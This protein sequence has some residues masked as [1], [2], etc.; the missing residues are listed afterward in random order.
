MKSYRISIILEIWEVEGVLE[1]LRTVRLNGL[2]SN[3]RENPP[4]PALGILVE[5]DW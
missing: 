5:R 2:Y 4:D 3:Y 1:L